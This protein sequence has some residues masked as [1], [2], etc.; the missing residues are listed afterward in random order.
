M[1]DDWTYLA[2]ETINMFPIWKQ[3]PLNLGKI[4]DMEAYKKEM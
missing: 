2:E 3:Y 4:T 1:T